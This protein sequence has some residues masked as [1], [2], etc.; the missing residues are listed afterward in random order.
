MANVNFFKVIIAPLDIDSARRIKEIIAFN[1]GSLVR[2]NLLSRL[3]S[4]RFL[5]YTQNL[6]NLSLFSYHK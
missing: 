1:S 2:L 5:V 3:N 4:T 6:Q